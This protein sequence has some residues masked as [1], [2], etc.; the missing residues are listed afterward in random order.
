MQ[1]DQV[2]ELLL[3]DYLDGEMEGANKEA[4]Q[5]HLSQCPHCR[6]EGRIIQKLA[7]EPFRNLERKTPSDEV[8][9]RIQRQIEKEREAAISTAADPGGRWKTFFSGGRGFAAATA[10]VFVILLVVTLLFKG[11]EK[12]EQ[13]TTPGIDYATTLF[14][15][16][17]T[18][19]LE[20]EGFGTVIEDV[21]L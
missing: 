7:M 13:A 10:A 17:G 11:P 6:E 16:V 14:E 5:G 20:E 2:R 1:C 18:A 21:F 3:T 8:W 15:T 4:L 19:T 12:N 9:E